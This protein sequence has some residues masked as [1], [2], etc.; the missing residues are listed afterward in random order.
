MRGRKALVI[1]LLVVSSANVVGCGALQS[2]WHEKFDWKAED[3]FDDPQVVALCRAIEANDLEEIDR[4]VTAG[5]DVNALGKDNMTPLLWA[6]PDNQSDRFEKLLELGAD[7][8]VIFQSNFN[9]D[10]K[11]TFRGTSI[12]HLASATWFPRYFDLVFAH[13]GDPNLISDT[14]LGKNLTPIFD[15]INGP[16][17]GD[18]K[19]IARLIELGADLDYVGGFGRTPAGYAVTRGRFDVVL[20]LLEAGADFRIYWS[21]SNQQLIHSL[22]MRERTLGDSPREQRAAYRKVLEWLEQRGVSIAD[23]REDLKRWSEHEPA[24]QEGE[25]M[26]R[27]VAQRKERE[28]SEDSADAAED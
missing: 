11:V 25:R 27:E 14:P 12:T 20:Q 2:T 18:N 4:L 15:V 22:I 8:N 6:Y 13:G 10:G 17:E 28:A 21:H 7:P 23:A 3:Y 16:E 9:S 26:T 1:L 19:K 5:A 24:G